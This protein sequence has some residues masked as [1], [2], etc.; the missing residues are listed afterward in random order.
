MAYMYYNNL[1]NPASVES[2]ENTIATG[3]HL[4]VPDYCLVNRGPFENLVIYNYW[5][6]QVNPDYP[7]ASMVFFFR[8]GHQSSSGNKAADHYAWALRSGDVTTVPLPAAIWLF[9]RS[10]TASA[11]RTS[12]ASAG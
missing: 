9:I 1:G 11:R 3:C 10:P 4:F 5:R 7:N 6:G 2:A 12:A 8:T